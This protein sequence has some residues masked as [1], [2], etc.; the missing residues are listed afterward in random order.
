M[1]E[2]PPERQSVSE[3]A[4]R[5]EVFYEASVDTEGWEMKLENARG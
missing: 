4:L 2:F 5:L 3:K 1:E